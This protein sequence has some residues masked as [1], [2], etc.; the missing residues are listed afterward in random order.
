MAPSRFPRHCAR[1]TANSFK[2]IQRSGT[3]LYASSVQLHFPRLFL[4]NPAVSLKG[5]SEQRKQVYGEPCAA[6]YQRR[7]RSIQ[8]ISSDVYTFLVSRSAFVKA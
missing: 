1:A 4:N 2:T 6:S 7:Y 3:H 5:L 8:R